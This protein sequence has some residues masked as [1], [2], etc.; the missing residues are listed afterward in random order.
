MGSQH[1]YTCLYAFA[2]HCT[3][4]EITKASHLLISYDKVELHL[5]F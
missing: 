1:Y 5:Y 4:P 3:E 2:V